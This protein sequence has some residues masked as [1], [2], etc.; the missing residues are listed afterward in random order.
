VND[1][2]VLAPLR[3]ECRAA[4]R[5]APHADVLHTGMGARRA[6]DAAA[7]ASS[8]P[9]RAVAVVGFCG[10]LDGSLEPGDVVVADELRGNNGQ[11]FP[12][13]HSEEVAAALADAGLRARRGPLLSVPHAV[14]GAE[15]ARLASDGS[16]AV[17][18]E[19][20]WLAEAAA[21]RPFTALRAVVD[22]PS[23]ELVRFSTVLGGIKAYR[24]LGRAAGAL[25]MW[26]DSLRTEKET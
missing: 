15:R 1:L 18:M 19:S 8:R 20:A 5:G 17:D 13:R 2:L 22:T 7:V 6:R 21:G 12:C 16:I 11:P 26:A 23:H 10:A 3:L 9:A 4:R 25:E 24:A 14:R